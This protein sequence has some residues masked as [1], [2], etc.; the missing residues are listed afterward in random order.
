MSKS[1]D[2]IALLENFVRIA[3]RGSISAAARDR[4]LSQASSSRQLAE[5]EERLGTQLIQRSTHALSLTR[6]GEACLRD[7]RVMIAGWDA[8]VDAMQA[9]G[10]APRGKLTVVAPVALGQLHLARAALGFQQIYPDIEIAW[11]LQDDP[12]RFAEMGCDLWIKVG[13]V[14]DDGL[15]V[16]PLGRIA[17]MVV[18]AP[19][20]G[21]GGP[22]AL[23]ALPC[24]VLD[25]FEGARIPLASAQGARTEIT[26]QVAMRTNNIFTAR[27]AALMGV[28][29][30]VM[31]RWMV[32]EDLDRG[33]LVDAAPG[34]HAPEL[35][36]NAAFL[37]AQ[38]QT[39]RLRLFRGHIARAV[40]DM[41]GIGDI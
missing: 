35:I 33:T 6:A 28:G 29:F 7:A 8:L 13:P 20:F 14:P 17:R 38:R 27:E 31:P 10:G 2:R 16:E 32:Q 24:A 41:P 1:L 19:G 23:E 25:Q 40:R 9:D 4:A 37:P 5:L 3:E 30:A 22:E 11:Q 36:V 26:P 15:I 18:A 12:L 21:G 34:W 39:H